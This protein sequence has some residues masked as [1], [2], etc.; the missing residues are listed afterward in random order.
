[1]RFS[2]EELLQTASK[3]DKFLK[4]QSCVRAKPQPFR[5]EKAGKK[6]TVELPDVLALHHRRMRRSGIEPLSSG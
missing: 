4:R 2:V 3:I 5:G 1:M 6:A